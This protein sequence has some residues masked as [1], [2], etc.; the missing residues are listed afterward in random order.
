MHGAHG[1]IRFAKVGCFTAE[2]AVVD[3]KQHDA[4]GVGLE[5]QIAEPLFRH[6]VD[7]KFKA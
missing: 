1:K 7:E 6:R 5:I 3:A 4:A 2:L